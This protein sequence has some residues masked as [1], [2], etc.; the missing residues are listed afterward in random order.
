MIHDGPRI[1]IAS[2][3]RSLSSR[4]KQHKAIEIIWEVNFKNMAGEV[5]K[6]DAMWSIFKILK[7]KLMNT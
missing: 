7:F 2:Y 6:N 4:H 1:N 5:L 3:I